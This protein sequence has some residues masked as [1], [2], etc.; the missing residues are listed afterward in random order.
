M[1]IERP[2]PLHGTA[3]EKTE[4]IH[5][6]LCR[7]ADALSKYDIAEEILKSDC[8]TGVTLGDQFQATLNLY[9]SLKED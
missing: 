1:E 9:Q 3:E 7:L 5:E 4:Q 2:A 8:G 6:Y